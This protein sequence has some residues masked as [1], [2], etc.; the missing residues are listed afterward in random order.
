MTSWF[1]SLATLEGTMTQ[2]EITKQICHIQQI[3]ECQDSGQKQS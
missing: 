2:V 3:L 1:N